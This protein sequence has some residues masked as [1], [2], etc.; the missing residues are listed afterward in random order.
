MDEKE[1]FIIKPTHK[2]EVKFNAIPSEERNEANAEGVKA[3]LENS[4]IK[5]GLNIERKEREV[6]FILIVF[7]LCC[8]F[9]Q[10]H[11][12]ASTHFFYKNVPMEIKR[13][14]TFFENNAQIYS[15]QL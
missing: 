11:A 12:H 14:K 3:A 4:I 6:C 15:I 7:K 8:F 10:I 13:N 9:F 1:V 2:G 5:F